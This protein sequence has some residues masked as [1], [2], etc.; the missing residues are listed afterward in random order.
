MYL[1]NLLKKRSIGFYLCLIYL[2]IS[3]LSFILGIISLT[4]GRCATPYASMVALCV[5]PLLIPFLPWLPYV[6]ILVPFFLIPFII[7]FILNLFILYAIGWASERFFRSKKAKIIVAICFVLGFVFISFFL[8]RYYLTSNVNCINS[9]DKNSCYY[10]SGVN[11]GDFSSCDKIKVLFTKGVCYGEIAV[12]TKN[13]GSCDKLISIYDKEACYFEVA[14]ATNNL[15]W[16]D[17][18]IGTSSTSLQYTKATCYRFIIA[19]GSDPSKCENLEVKYRDGCYSSI[20]KKTGNESLCDKISN[21]S[22][23][24]KGDCYFSAAIA[25]NNSELCKK[26]T[27]YSEMNNCYWRIGLAT[28]NPNICLLA[29]NIGTRNFCLYQVAGE[30][31]NSSICN[32]TSADVGETTEKLNEKKNYCLSFITT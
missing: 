4:I 3:L 30:T 12:K 21:S 14:I 5:L 2:I 17:K 26:V 6:S 13:Y 22:V 15:E 8:T 11:K 23:A 31:K 27:F 9:L 29:S 16:C 19:A 7:G 20:G 32:L 24:D 18:I 25:T 1:I 10:A 28:R